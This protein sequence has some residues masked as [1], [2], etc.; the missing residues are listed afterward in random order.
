MNS[1]CEMGPGSHDQHFA[2]RVALAPLIAMQPGGLLQCDADVK[3]GR[4]ETEDSNSKS[5]QHNKHRK[6][7]AEPPK[8]MNLVAYPALLICFAQASIDNVSLR[9]H[10]FW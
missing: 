7:P 3:S 4:S 2:C 10:G 5:C 9:S 1:S 8:S 6:S